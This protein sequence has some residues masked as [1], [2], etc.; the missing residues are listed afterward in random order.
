MWKS[1]ENRVEAVHESGVKIVRFTTLDSK[2]LYIVGNRTL[3]LHM[4]YEGNGPE[5]G[6]RVLSSPPYC[7]KDGTQLTEDEESLFR[8]LFTEGILFLGI[9]WINY[10]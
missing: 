2:G 3:E 10:N 5:F 8:E 1:D 7:W 6:Y 9:H 4:T